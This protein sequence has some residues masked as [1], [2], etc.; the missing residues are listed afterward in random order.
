MG[1]VYGPNYL[2]KTALSYAS[3]MGLQKD[4]GL[5]GDNYPQLSSQF[6]LQEVR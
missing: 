6:H 3:A 2:D 5:V 4:I 1:V